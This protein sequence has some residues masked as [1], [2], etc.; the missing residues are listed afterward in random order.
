MNADCGVIPAELRLELE[1]RWPARLQK[2]TL[3]SVRAWPIPKAKVLASALHCEELVSVIVVTCNGIGF[4]K[5][6][7]TS[8]LVNVRHTPYELIIID[9]ASHDG[10]GDMLKHIASIN[11]HVRII[12]NSNNVGF[13]GAVNQGLAAAR[14]NILI[15]LNSDT[16]VPHWWPGELISHLKD[17]RVGL[18]GPTTNRSGTEADLS[19][20]YRTYGEFLAFAE[21]QRNAH[22]GQFFETSMLSMFCVAMRRKTYERLGPLDERYGIGLFEDD[23][24]SLRALRCGFRLHCA[25]DSFVH[26]FGQGSFG[27]WGSRSRYT[28]LHRANLRRF[29][30][31]WDIHWLNRSK[32]V[33]PEYERLRL[34]IQELLVKHLPPGATALVVSRGD[35]QLVRAAGRT[36]WHFPRSKDGGYAGFYPPDAGACIAHL[37]ELQSA[38]A[39]FLVFPATAL[40]WLDHYCGL[41]Q[42]LE[43]NAV[44]IYDD[45]TIAVAYQLN[46][47]SDQGLCTE[48][49]SDRFGPE[50]ASYREPKER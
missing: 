3:A 39:D 37:K 25:R 32:R 19:C 47:S 11:Q 33:S 23:D 15:L 10:T 45:P 24:Y 2:Q 43:V 14:G 46:R 7:L 27:E 22:A 36:I 8:I 6:C 21:N 41:N 4:A 35:D 31:K 50:I 12:A 18:I 40:W 17:D 42:F 44:K 9:N 5:L 38:G 28:G 48:G 16:L 29:E 30:Q 20:K 34:S 49:C 1:R 13:A 26:H